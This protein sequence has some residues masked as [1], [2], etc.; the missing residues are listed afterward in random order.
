M[1]NPILHNCA[2]SADGW[3]LS[4]VSA[5]L[6]A[7]P[8][9][10]E[11]FTG[12]HTAAEIEYLSTP[13]DQLDDGG[14]SAKKQGAQPQVLVAPKSD[15]PVVQKY[16]DR[17]AKTPRAIKLVWAMRTAVRSDC[18]AGASRESWRVAERA[19]TALIA[20]IESLLAVAPQA[21]DEERQ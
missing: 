7:K 9:I 1:T 19:E 12:S 3:C 13:K 10:Q 11:R 21:Q 4:C 18:G 5:A 8:R 17:D 20:E 16:R 15:N 2:H 14:E 6:Q